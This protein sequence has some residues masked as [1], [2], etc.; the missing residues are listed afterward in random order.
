MIHPTAIV[1]PKADIG[2]GVE[3]GPY[4]IIQEDVV[5]GEGTRVGPHVFIGRGT[6]IGKE[7][8]IFQFASIG[9]GPQAM[10]Y[11]GEKTSLLIGDHNI[12]RECVTLNRGTVQGGG[13]TVIGNGNLFMAYS[14]VGHDCTLGNHVILA[15]SAALAGHIL[16]E[17]HATIGGLSAVHQFCRVGAYAFVSGMTGIAQ[18]L[19]PYMLASGNR[20]RL[21]GL[22]TVG[23]KRF[24]FSETAVK[25]LKRAY[26]ILFRSS[27]TLEKALNQIRED[28]ISKVPEVQHLLQFIQE[29]KRGIC[30]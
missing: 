27:L 15:N 13:N 6:R 17:D 10:I 16:L 14:H 7:C 21:F 1:D 19:P 24:K 5:I 9:E 26:R 4:S 23:L 8:Q 12:I 3:I 22:N 30:R 28:E 11:K 29:T 18:D 2:E 25:A 20:A